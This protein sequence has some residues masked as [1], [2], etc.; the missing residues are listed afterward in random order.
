MLEKNNKESAAV[1]A[2]WLDESLPAKE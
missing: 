1:I 2:Q